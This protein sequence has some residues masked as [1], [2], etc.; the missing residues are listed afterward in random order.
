MPPIAVSVAVVDRLLG[1]RLVP[2]GVPAGLV[3]T[4]QQQIPLAIPPAQQLLS[5]ILIT[6]FP[7]EFRR[8]T[9]TIAR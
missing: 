1:P 8:G 3:P 2:V 4:R 6:A 7:S 9:A 5:L